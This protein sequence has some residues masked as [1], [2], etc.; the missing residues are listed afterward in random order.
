MCL[1]FLTVTIFLGFKKQVLPQIVNGI[2]ANYRTYR[3][4]I[5][6]KR[7]HYWSLLQAKCIQSASSHSIS[8]TSILIGPPPTPRSSVFQLKFCIYFSPLPGMLHD[9]LIWFFMFIIIPPAQE[10]TIFYMSMRHFQ[11][12]GARRATRN[13]LQTG[14]PQFWSHLCN[15]NVI[16][17]IL[18]SAWNDIHFLQ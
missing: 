16:G 4:V 18:L 11:I 10:S 15:S 9:Q 2:H 12:P 13:M 3:F 5:L 7:A 1:F 8:L 6:S 14:N 17:C